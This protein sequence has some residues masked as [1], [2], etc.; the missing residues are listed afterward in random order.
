MAW[1]ILEGLDRTGKSSIANLYKKDGYEVVHMSAP[2]KKYSDAGYAGPSYLDD[3]LELVIKY[4]GK[5][6]V[7]D[8]SWMGELVW[9]HVYGR[10]PM[11]TEDGLEILQ[12][13]EDRNS[14]KRILMVDPDQKAHWQRCVDNKEPMNIQQFKIANALFTK[15]AHRYNFIPQQLKDFNVNPEDLKSDSASSKQEEPAKAAPSKDVTASVNV[16]S[17][18]KVHEEE[19]ELTKL[20]KANAIRDVLAKRILKQKGGTFDQLEEDMKN[21]LKSQL[22]NIFSDTK[23][24]ESLSDE[25]I[26]VLKVFCQ[27]L[28]EKAK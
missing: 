14:A 3:I 5:D 25:E 11:L 16:N 26:S 13:F 8:R 7:W 10:E 27:R 24:K 22:S 12:E 19:D 15:M 28:K 1:V 23:T 2:D 20:E 4:D 21:F 18:K 17:S 9:P 6:V